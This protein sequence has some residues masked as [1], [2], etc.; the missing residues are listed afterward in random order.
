MAG[1]DGW[2]STRGLQLPRLPRPKLSG[3][4]LL[5]RPCSRRC[6]A[7]A[8][9]QP[10]APPRPAHHAPSPPLPPAP[11]PAPQVLLRPPVVTAQDARGDRHRRAH[12]AAAGGGLWHAARDIP[13][14]WSRPQSGRATT[15]Q[16]RRPRRRVFGSPVPRRR[17]PRERT[18]LVLRLRHCGTEPH[19]TF[20]T[21]PPPTTPYP[22]FPSHSTSLDVRPPPPPLQGFAIIMEPYDERLPHIPDPVLQLRCAPRVARPAP[23]GRAAG[24]RA[25]GVP[26][27]LPEGLRRWVQRRHAPTH[28]PRSP[29]AA[30]MR[31]W[32][33]VRCS[34]SSNQSS[35]PAARS[36]P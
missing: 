21:A 11:C 14:G 2:A 1:V 6:L 12:P 36:A 3:A 15:A 9:C 16:Q 13:A 4:F 30:W 29:A 18:A 23:A 26:R 19:A 7:E 25:R 24:G 8:A 31:R 20:P 28:H 27:R 34:P 22:H 10:S 5:P 17:A 35:S 33:C 32:R